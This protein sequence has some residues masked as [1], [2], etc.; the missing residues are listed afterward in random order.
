MVSYKFK[1]KLR[2][3]V[4]GAKVKRYVFVALAGLVFAVLVITSYSIHYT[5]LYED[6]DVEKHKVVSG[7]TLY[8]ICKSYGLKLSDIYKANPSLTDDGKIY[9]GDILIVTKISNI[10][11]VKYTE[12]VEK[13]EEMPYDTIIIEDNSMYRNNFV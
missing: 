10:V 7:E 11:N 8:N 6:I 5:K 13:Q 2:W 12:Y 3:L 1:N 4:P 9:K